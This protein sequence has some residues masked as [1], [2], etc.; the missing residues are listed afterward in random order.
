MSEQLLYKIGLTLIP[1]V[2]DI[3]G[4]KLVAYCGGPEAVFREKRRQ[5]EKIPGIGTQTIDNIV[6]QNV[7]SRAEEEIAFIEKRN[8]KPLFYLDKD[9]PK[10]MQHCADSPMLIYYKG[11][12]NLNQQRIIGI[13]GTRNASDY[14]KHFCERIVEELIPDQVLIVSGLA[15]GIDSCAHRASLKYGIPTVGVLA[16]GLDRIY[17]YSNK[18]L[19]EKMIENGGLLTEFMS[20]TN[21][22]RE[23]FPRRNRIVA[24]MIDAL[25]V[26]ESAK[27]GG[28]LITAE[29]AN[30]YSRD[31][32][33]VPGRIGDTYSEGCN[34]LIR[35]NKAALLESAANIRYLMGWNQPSS[36]VSAQ[37]KL[38]K[39]FTEDEQK[40][41]DVFGQEKEC[42]ID[43]I[44]L[45]SEFPASKL[46]GLLLTLEF[47][48]ILVALPGKKYKIV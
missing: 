16:H 31:V 8:I 45:R 28:A 13:V 44:M 21:P 36:S 25:I 15:Y 48:G 11:S 10:R 40:I 39:E 9:Y 33:A 24:G 37:T 29:I 23:N 7:L 18:G 14:G 35:I 43:D 5:L 6:N 3:G 32:F 41:M 34:Y 30:S 20:Q 42:G 17:P 27:R 1:G 12:T 38:F 4:K 47:D 19:S 2:G 26:V 46:A 22:D